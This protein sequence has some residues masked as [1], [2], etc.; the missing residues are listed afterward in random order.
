M[1]KLK[2]GTEY[3][4]IGGITFVLKGSLIKTRLGSYYKADI[5]APEGDFEDSIFTK[6]DMWEFCRVN[7]PTKK[8]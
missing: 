7:K 3:K 5:K 2:V 6:S 8:K 1:R 4:W